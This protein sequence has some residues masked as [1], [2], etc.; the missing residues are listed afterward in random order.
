MK[1]RY[2]FWKSGRVQLEVELTQCGGIPAGI[3]M[4]RGDY[5]TLRGAKIAL[6]KKYPGEYKIH[7]PDVHSQF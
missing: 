2:R 5:A 4:P 1:Y 7:K 6:A 3:W